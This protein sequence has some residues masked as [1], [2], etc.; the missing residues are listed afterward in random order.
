MAKRFNRDRI[1]EGSW[2]YFQESVGLSQHNKDHNESDPPHNS[3]IIA[4]RYP[5]VASASCTVIS[6]YSFRP[7][8]ELVIHQRKI[9]RFMC[10]CFIEELYYSSYHPNE[11]KQGEKCESADLTICWV[12][13]LAF[14]RGL[15][16][17]LQLLLHLDDVTG[18][19][20]I[21]VVWIAK[22]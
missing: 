15:L 22:N 4:S 1:F 20:M 3:F 17:R 19:R 18:L 21:G 14:P 7:S 9:I 2:I 12:I 5:L 8:N 6:R 13:A 16:I 10:N 11:E